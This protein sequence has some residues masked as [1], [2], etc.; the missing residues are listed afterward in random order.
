MALPPLPQTKQGGLWMFSL[1][2]NWAGEELGNL[3]VC[4]SDPSWRYFANQTQAQTGQ[5]LNS[6]SSPK[7]TKPQT[8]GPNMLGSKPGYPQGPFDS[9]KTAPWSGKQACNQPW[10]CPDFALTCS[11]LRRGP[12]A[13]ELVFSHTL[14]LSEGWIRLGCQQL[15]VAMVLP[16]Q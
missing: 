7:P 16:G 14:R 2:L 13:L 1:G 6:Y 3:G 15:L 10:L 4:S 8:R 9:L 12:L 5:N 11:G